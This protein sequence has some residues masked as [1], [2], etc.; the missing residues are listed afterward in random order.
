MRICVPTPTVD[1]M[2]NSSALRFM[3]GRPMPAPKPM[4]RTDSGAVDHPSRMARSRSGM[5]GPRSRIRSVTPSSSTE[6]SI[7][8]PR[9]WM[10]R[11]SSTS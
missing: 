10:T 3:L 7:V 2:S 11:F 4:L 6:K 5:P 8:P 1:W 9:E